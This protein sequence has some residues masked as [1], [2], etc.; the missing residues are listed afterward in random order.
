MKAPVRRREYLGDVDGTIVVQF[1]KQLTNTNSSIG[2]A[3]DIA[4]KWTAEGKSE[5]PED[6]GVE[7]EGFTVE[8]HFYHERL[9]SIELTPLC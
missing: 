1:L 5:E 4:S 7:P 3:I 9:S 2:D 8:A 6:F